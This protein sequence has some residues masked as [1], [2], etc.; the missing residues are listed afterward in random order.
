MSKK[1]TVEFPEE[2]PGTYEMMVYLVDTYHNIKAVSV[3]PS[4]ILT[5]HDY[6]IPCGFCGNAVLADF[7]NC[8]EECCRECLKQHLQGTCEICNNLIFDNESW[9]TTVTGIV[10]DSCLG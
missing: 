4:T 6:F 3:G 10:H 8:K 1:I 7:Y 2:K 9:Q 5:I